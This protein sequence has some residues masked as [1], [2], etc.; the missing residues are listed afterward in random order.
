MADLLRISSKEQRVRSSRLTARYPR[1]KTLQHPAQATGVV[2][3]GEQAVVTSNRRL[4]L[5]GDFEIF[6]LDSP[7]D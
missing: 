7:R 4:V 2:L 3:V 1:I 6:N 5:A